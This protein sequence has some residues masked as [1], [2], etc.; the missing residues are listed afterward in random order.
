MTAQSTLER[1]APRLAK[2]QRDRATEICRR[3]PCGRDGWCCACWLAEERR[4]GHIARTRREATP[5]LYDRND[6]RYARD[7]PYTLLIYE[8][9]FMSRLYD[10]ELE[11]A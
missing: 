4:S 8:G 9:G 1:V 3:R 6:R 10:W 7:W 2:A 5:W 11:H